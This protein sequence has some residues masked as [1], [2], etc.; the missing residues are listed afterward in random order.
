MHE[1]DDRAY[2]PGPLLADVSLNHA[3]SAFPAIMMSGLAVACLV[4]R[5][6]LRTVSWISQLLPAIYLLNVWFQYLH[7]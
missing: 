5:Q 7:G 1:I 2:P 4:L 6:A 3:T